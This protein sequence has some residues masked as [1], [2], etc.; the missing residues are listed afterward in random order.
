MFNLRQKS[1]KLVDGRLFI[2]LVPWLWTV[3]GLVIATSVGVA[4]WLDLPG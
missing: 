4:G 1:F 3:V 2:N